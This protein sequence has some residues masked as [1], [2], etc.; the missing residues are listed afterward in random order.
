[1]SDGGYDDEGMELPGQLSL[2]SGMDDDEP[3]ASTNELLA[4]L[5]GFVRRWIDVGLTDGEV[6]TMAQCFDNLDDA[7]LNGERPPDDWI[8]AKWHGPA[9]RPVHDLPPL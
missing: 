7:M 4:I 9:S 1:M 8:K 2:W 3:P 5:R 6:A